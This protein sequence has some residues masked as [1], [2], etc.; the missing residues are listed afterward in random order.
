MAGGPHIGVSGINCKTGL[1]EIIPADIL[2]T[3]VY[4]DEDLIYGGALHD[5]GQPIPRYKVIEIWADHFRAA[6]APIGGLEREL[7]VVL[8]Q[9]AVPKKRGRR[10]KYDKEMTK[11]EFFNLMEEN[12]PFTDQ[13][14]KWNCQERAFEALVPFCQRRFKKDPNPSSLRGDIKKWLPEWEKKNHFS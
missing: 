13:D 1:R 5:P 14:P 3:L 12:G 10:P 6:H 11:K 4:N 8:Q 9:S 7:Q 2:K